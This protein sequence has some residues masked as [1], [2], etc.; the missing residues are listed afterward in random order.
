MVLQRMF[1]ITT[2]FRLLI[3]PKYITTFISG[4]QSLNSLCQAAMVE[5]GT[6]NTLGPYTWNVL[7]KIDKNP[8]V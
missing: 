3:S 6:T 4:A 8:M 7:Y 5:R 2:L 1:N